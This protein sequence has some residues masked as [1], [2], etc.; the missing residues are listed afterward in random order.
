MSRH[1]ESRESTSK[2]AFKVRFRKDSGL[3]ELTVFSPSLHTGNV[4]N[5]QHKHILQSPKEKKTKTQI[6]RTR[7]NE[8]GVESVSLM[9]N[10]T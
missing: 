9:P 6:K 7:M 3:T 1:E 8:S 5:M 2:I 4:E 10:G